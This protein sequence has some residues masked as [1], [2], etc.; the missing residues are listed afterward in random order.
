MAQRYK[1]DDGGAV[2][3][4]KTAA[5]ADR[6]AVHAQPGELI[7]AEARSG[8]GQEEVIAAIRP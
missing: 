2:A 4:R 1:V 8:E 6:S 5:M 3:F 7:V